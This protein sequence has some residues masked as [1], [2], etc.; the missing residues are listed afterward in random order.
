MYAAIGILAGILSI[1]MYL[2]YIKDTI[3]GIT[4]PHRASWLIWSSLGLIA[5]F[6]QL[7]KGATNSLWMTAAQTLGTLLVFLLALKLGVGGFNK[8]DKIS[9]LVAALGLMIWLF[10]KEAAYALLIT[11][12]VDAIGAGLTAIKAYEMP[13]SETLITWILSA[14]SGLLGAIAVGKPSFILMAYPLYVFLANSWVIAGIYLGH[15]RKTMIQADS[16]IT[17]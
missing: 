9:L 1:I 15:K 6:T 10:T 3:K 2:P 11:I 8:R 14:V 4:H 16:S 13:E 7:A 5:F 17:R 12:A